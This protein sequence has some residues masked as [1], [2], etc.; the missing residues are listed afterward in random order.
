M[1]GKSVSLPYICN[2]YTVNLKRFNT[3]KRN[4]P[5]L[6]TIRIIHGNLKEKREVTRYFSRNPNVSK[7]RIKYK[8]QKNVECMAGKLSINRNKF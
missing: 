8:N 1:A 7:F 2:Q 4:S 5:H 6:Y 3:F